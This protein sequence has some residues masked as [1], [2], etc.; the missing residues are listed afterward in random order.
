MNFTANR[1]IQVRA[2]LSL[3]E[4]VALARD[5][6][7]A[8]STKWLLYGLFLGL[9][10]VMIALNLRVGRSLAEAIAHNLFWVLFG[11]VF[12]FLGLPLVYRISF[13]WARRATPAL[14]QDFTY[15]YSDDGFS[16]TSGLG[17]MNVPWA[18][19]RRVEET[20]RTLLLFVGSNMA[21]A[22]PARP[23]KEAGVLGDW[24]ALVR[25]HVKSNVVLLG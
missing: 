21:H 23:L 13:L 5:Q 10:L 24:R 17:E 2:T 3:G 18:S 12:L 11:P 9:P 7:N 8:S 6:M 16:V 20:P 15:R 1:P 22:L 19:I 14:A 4:Q 25:S